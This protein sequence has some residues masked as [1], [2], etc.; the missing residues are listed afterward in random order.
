MHH[1]K[2]F[3]LIE[4]LIVIAI[5]AILSSATVLILNPVEMMKQ[6][7]DGTRVS[8]IQSLSKAISL[9][10]LDNDLSGLL[11]SKVVYV[12]LV[13]TDINCGGLSLPSLPTGWSYRCVTN[14]GNLT[15]TDSSG[16]FPVDLSVVGAG[17]PLS[18]LPIDPKNDRENY[19]AVAYING[20]FS[21]HSSSI[22]S[23][24]QKASIRGSLTT[25]IANGSNPNIASVYSGGDWVK[26]SGNATYGTSDFQVMKY[27]AKC[28][29]ENGLALTD[30][31]ES[32]YETY[33]DTD[34]PC[35]T[36][37]NRYV[38]SRK[39][40]Y[41]ITRLTHDEA[42]A[43]CQTVGAHLMTNEEWMTIARNI[44]SV[45]SNWTNG[46]VGDGRIYGGHTDNNPAKV[47]QASYDAEGYVNI[48]SPGTGN[49]R[50][51]VL[52]NGEIIWDFSGNAWERVMRTAGDIKTVINNPT[53]SGGT[54]WCN[55]GTTLA[56]YITTWTADISQ[57]YAGPLNT[58]YDSGDGTGRIY[59]TSGAASG[60]TLIRG[61][62]GYWYYG[63]DT[64]GIY[65]MDIHQAS[66]YEGLGIGFRCAR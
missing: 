19:Y 25:K 42:K 51:L 60:D 30:Y 44:E 31:T 56:P 9:L 35:T 63:V 53:C 64:A 11:T 28:I 17:N 66:T 62:S 52:S 3:T 4:L 23:I 54:G 47:L 15:K 46:S 22:E 2:A 49:R 7:R 40:G 61:G 29:D 48:I 43:Y 5:I 57:S 50:T 59:V 65:A 13:G 34:R 33:R 18:S 32:T 12:S 37:N 36:A 10:S 8:D 16:W 41:V 27:E 38:S 14:V 21:A 20:K 55:Y 45:S 6:G 24:K 1:S 26:V 58:S 39:D